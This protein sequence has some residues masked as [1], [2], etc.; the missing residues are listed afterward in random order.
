MQNPLLVRSIWGRTKEPRNVQTSVA[1]PNKEACKAF[2]VRASVSAWAWP[3]CSRVTYLDGLVQSESSVSTRR[4]SG[5]ADSTPPANITH[6]I[7]TRRLD[8]INPQQFAETSQPG[9]KNVPL[10]P[11]RTSNEEKL[12]VKLDLSVRPCTARSDPA[13]N[14][15]HAGLGVISRHIKCI[16]SH[17]IIST[18]MCGGASGSVART[19]YSFLGMFYSGQK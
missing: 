2:R 5:R 12:H 15:A 7:F 19:L 14:Q 4:S 6:I 10:R 8:E 9:F 11:R 16:L 1:S 18:C 17:G 3:S 13:C